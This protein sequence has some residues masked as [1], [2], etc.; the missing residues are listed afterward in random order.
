MIDS[1]IPSSIHLA[2]A[3]G[4]FGAASARLREAIDKGLS[5]PEIQDWFVSFHGLYC[6]GDCQALAHALLAAPDRSPSELLVC[7]RLFFQSGRFEFAAR[8][9]EEARRLDASNPDILVMSASAYERAGQATRARELLAA[10]V[11]LDP[12][13]LRAIRQLAH[14]DRLDGRLD[15]ARARIESRLE[16]EPSSGDW[17]LRYELADI[18]ERQNDHGRAMSVLLEAKQQLSSR[19]PVSEADRVATRQWE[20]TR[21][22]TTSRLRAW[23]EASPQLTPQQ[24]LCLLAGFPRSGTTLLERILSSHPDV[25]GTD[26]SGILRKFFETPLVL[27]AA[28]AEEALA[29]LDGFLPEELSDGRADYL[30]GTAEHI[31]EGLANRLLVEKDPLLTTS[32]AVPLRLFPEARILMPLRDPRDVVMSYFFTIVPLAA[33]SAAALDLGSTCRFYAECMRH[34]LLLKDRLPASQWMV[35]RYEDLVA[36]PESHTRKLAAFLGIPWTPAMLAAHRQTGGRPSSTPSYHD[37]SRPLYTSSLARWK[38]HE[39]ALAPHLH[40]LDP[41]LEAFGYQ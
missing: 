23:R 6:L 24:P 31:G 27:E 35:S 14:L 30:R 20:V 34:W 10:A 12:W 36:D 38:N 5:A 3:E 33:N 8:L 11:Q 17:R 1:E 9:S 2:L 22:L 25:V 21:G 32:L 28:S 7:A 15:Q 16:R 19:V 40:H 13:H 29:E 4:D 39:A 26:E 37:V 41:Y 18:L